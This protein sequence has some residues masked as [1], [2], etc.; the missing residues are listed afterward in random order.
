L[1]I[2]AVSWRDL[3]NPSA[4][5]AEVLMDR[6]LQSFAER[7][8][9]VSLVCGGPVAERKY[10]VVN[11]GG[12]YGQYLIAPVICSTR[13]SQS[14]VLIDVENGLP[15]FSPL[16]RRRASI[17]LVHHVHTDQWHDR[18]PTA[19]ARAC[20]AV[21]R[22]VMPVVYRN[23]IF[24][25]ISKSTAA[26]LRDI[27]VPEDHIRTI[28]SG[29]DLPAISGVK[30]SEDPLF[31]SLNR[32]VPHK[33]I[34]L[35][36][37]AWE[38]AS[39]DIPGRLLIVGDGP[40][41]E[42][43]RRMA[44]DIPRAEVTGRVS[45][46]TKQR[47][48]AESWGLVCAAHHEGWGMSVMEAAAV[49]TPTLAVDA[50]GIRDAVVNGETGILVHAPEA[51]L[52]STLAREWVAFASDHGLRERLGRAAQ[53]RA[54]EFSWDRAI[55]LW[56]DVLKE[57][58]DLTT[59]R[60]LRRSV[61]QL[62]SLASA[63]SGAL[64]TVGSKSSHKTSHPIRRQTPL[65]GH[66]P[67][68]VEGV[69]RSVQLL[70]GFR[71]QYDDPEGFY[72][73]LANDTVDLVEDYHSVDGQRV[74]DIGG[75]PGYFAQAFRRAGAESVFVEPFWESM[76]ERGRELGY[77]VI[78]DGLQLPFADGSFDVSHSSNVIEHVRDPEAFFHEMLRVVRPGGLMF[79][80]FTN[81]FSPFGG[82]ETS[83]W[84]Y[85]G[86]DKAAKRYEQKVGYA[87]KN[88]FG[89]SL[90][91]LDISEVLAWSR[92][93]QQ[94]QLIDTFPRY[95]PTWTKPLVALPGLREVVTWNL[96]VVMRRH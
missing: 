51:E 34:D 44:A 96:V 81:W 57:V 8:H 69:R 70:K 85:L 67:G 79:L 43:L 7:G 65:S 71:T 74:V 12:T 77:G 58:G 36:L 24:V 50:P 38:I 92:S 54:I 26:A 33:R 94:A 89:S 56:L 41:L 19:V 17:C 37:R 60:T 30:R 21:E 91:R 28:E 25:A 59:E 9:E 18:F 46:E 29:V 72:S 68:F 66:R 61:G 2:T 15:F 53:E 16:W 86:G 45:E 10:E 4:G 63:V 31:I 11:A 35:L 40:A 93:Q 42:D 88:L 73:L 90:F 23:R 78:G 13:F 48:L 47:L 49:A 3:A 87:P 14:D 82:H 6:L 80:A 83:P 52:V 55:D 1:R 39:V 95:Y 32:L 62:G 22:H 75:G 20:Q 27:G 64:T 5:G 84:H 76:T